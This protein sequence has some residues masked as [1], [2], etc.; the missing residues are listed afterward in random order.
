MKFGFCSKAAKKVTEYFTCP[1]TRGP[2]RYN[3]E[4]QVLESEL[5]VRYRIENGIPIFT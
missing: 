4:L 3:K 5:G 2:L 1:I